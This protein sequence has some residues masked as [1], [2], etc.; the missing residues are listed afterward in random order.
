MALTL[1]NTSK[2]ML[3]TEIS[4]PGRSAELAAHLEAMSVRACVFTGSE[5]MAAGGGTSISR[6]V[7]AVLTLLIDIYR[8]G[9][10]FFVVRTNVEENHPLI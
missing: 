1:C 8:S 7:L 5:V 3:R 2:M 4:H 10:L 9:D 6:R